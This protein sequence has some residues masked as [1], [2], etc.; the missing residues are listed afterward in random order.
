MLQQ[1]LK[2]GRGIGF[3]TCPTAASLARRLATEQAVEL[4]GDQLAVGV[5][6]AQKQAAISKAEG[7]RNPGQVVVARRQHMGLLVVQVLDAVFHTPQKNVGPGQR[8]RHVLQH[9][10]GMGQALQGTDRG[11][12]AQLGELPATHH[13]QQLHRELNL[14]NAASRHLH[15]VGALGV[16]STALGGVFTDL[17]VQYAQGVKHAVVQVAPEHERQYRAAQGMG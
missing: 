11:A 6:L 14:A 2:L 15:V 8:I 17:S 7:L 4:L 10:S 13:L 9:Q 3:L 1:I 5:Q 12:R 16:A